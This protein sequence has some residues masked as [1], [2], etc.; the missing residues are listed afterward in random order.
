MLQTDRTTLRPC[1]L[2]DTTLLA[3]ILGDSVTMSFWPQPLD[4]A[5]V[6]SWVQRSVAA[7]AEHGLGRWL[8]SERATG[9]IIGDCG[10][11]PG[12]LDGEPVWDLGYIIHHPF[13]RRGY[14][15]ECALAYLNYARSL[16][17]IDRIV[18]NMPDEHIASWRTAEA[19]GFRYVRSFANPRNRNIN[20]RIYTLDL[21][22]N[23]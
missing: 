3:P 8:I 11:L 16:N 10:I 1:I 20:T 19:L 9:V 18:A 17:V 23:T 22:S 5:A 15:A 6:E 14:A 4:G 21:L 7:H 13:W 2:A 12:T